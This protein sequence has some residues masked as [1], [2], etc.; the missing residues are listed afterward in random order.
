VVGVQL[1]DST[2]DYY[3]LYLGK[4]RLA[5][6]KFDDPQWKSSFSYREI[7]PGLL[8]LEGVL[9]GKK[10]RLMMRRMP[11][12]AFTLT[13]RGFHWINEFPFNH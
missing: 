7:G 4:R 9:D 13:N 12:T 10:T 8:A 6:G 3:S 1:M 11:E 2:S 5:L